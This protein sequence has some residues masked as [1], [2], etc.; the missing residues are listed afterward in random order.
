[1]PTHVSI[2]YSTSGHFQQTSAIL[3]RAHE[4]HY[5]QCSGIKPT[6]SLSMMLFMSIH[7]ISRLLSWR[8]RSA[9][10]LGIT[11]SEPEVKCHGWEREHKTQNIFSPPPRAPIVHK[12]WRIYFLRKHVIHAMKLNLNSKRIGRIYSASRIMRNRAEYRL[13]LSRRGRRP[14]RLKSDDVPRDWAG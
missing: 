11:G 13:I 9:K 2:I 14:S 3:R 7:L 6:S 12:L 5:V 8:A 4:L 10:N 1:M